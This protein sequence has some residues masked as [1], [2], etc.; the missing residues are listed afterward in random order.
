MTAYAYH[1]TTADAL[2]DIRE[3]GLLPNDGTRGFWPDEYPVEG[4]LFFCTTPEGARYYAETIEDNVGEA[5]ELR[6]PMPVRSEPDAMTD[7][8]DGR[9]VDHAIAAADIEVLKDGTWTALVI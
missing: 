4:R 5:V 7:G 3:Q 1:A 8:G 2:P 6:F 9:H